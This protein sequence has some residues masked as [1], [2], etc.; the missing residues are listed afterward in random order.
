MEAKKSE[1]LQVEKNSRLYFLIGL[2]LLLALTH[3]ALEWKT[4]HEPIAFDPEIDVLRPIDELPPVVIEKLP[5]PPKLESVPELKVFEDDEKITET[6]IESEEANQDYEIPDVPDFDFEEPVVEESIS[7]IVVEDAPIFPGCEDA[8]DKRACF[9]EQMLKHVKRVFNYPETAQE[10]GL[11][12]RVSVL[13]TIQKDGSIGDVRM[14]GPHQLLEEEAN[15]IISKLP[16]MTPGKQ[17]GKAVKVP[18]S[19]PIAFKLQ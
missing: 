6:V 18:F 2:T 12:G 15:R 5:P 8:Q 4:Y 7:F 9:Q 16:K 17:R 11:E 13:F 10:M 3:V 1:H 14:R 19:I